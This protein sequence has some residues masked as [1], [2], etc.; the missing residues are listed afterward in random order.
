VHDA[1]QSPCAT[2]PCYQKRTI[3]RVRNASCV[4]DE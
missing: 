3:R 1:T 4:C 2:P